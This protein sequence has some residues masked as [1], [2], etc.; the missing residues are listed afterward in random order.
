MQKVFSVTAVLL[1][2]CLNLKGQTSKGGVPKIKEAYNFSIT[3]KGYKAGTLFYLG[4]YF[5]DK[6]YLRDSSRTDESGKIVF[7]GD[8]KLEGGVYL[9]ATRS[10]ELLFDFIFTEPFFS[11]ETDSGKIIENMKVKGSVENAVFFD[12]SRFTTRMGMQANELDDKIK[13]AA[14]KGD[15]ASERIHREKYSEILKQLDTERK[16]IKAEHPQLLISKIF[17]MMED[18]DIPEPPKKA[19]G[20][21]DSAFAYYYYYNHYFDKYDFA[22]DRITRSPVFYPR[23]ERF[24]TKMTIQLADSINKSADI[25]L[26]KAMAGRE[27]FK[28]CLYW[29]TNHYE[30]SQYMCMDEVF[31]HMVDRYYS[32]GKADF[33]DSTL[34]IKMQDKANKLRYNLCGDRGK[35]LN[36]PDTNNTYHSLYNITASYT[37]LFFWNATCGHCKEEMPKLVEAYK[38][39]NKDRGPKQQLFV[40]MYSVSLT[41]NSDDW[42]RYLHDTRLPWKINVYDPQNESNFRYLYDVF[43]TPVLYLLDRNKKVIAKRI[44]AEQVEEFLRNY[45]KDVNKPY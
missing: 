10:K 16:R 37:M 11:L 13:A 15:T 8:K 2:L 32:S 25:V 34:L 17:N 3:L 1:I 12:Y 6:Q 18:V 35:N 44:K 38:N 39:L 24:M 5:G 21:I 14:A 41:E 26:R 20:S 31:V 30:E 36:L 7:K 9:I 40:D 23:F 45:D 4:Y 27:N 22:D 42:K 29:I 28:F 43:S 33:V 19:D